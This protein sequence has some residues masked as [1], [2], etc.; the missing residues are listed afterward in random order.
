MNHIMLDLE[1]M[2]TAPDAAIVQVGAVRFDL[3]TGI[4]CSPATHA[5]FTP[6]EQSPTPAL[7][8]WF[9]RTVALQSSLLAGG[10][11]DPDTVAWWRKGHA[12]AKISIESNAERLGVV[13][14]AFS[15]WYP[16]GAI[17]WSHGAAFDVP[18]LDCAYL[19]LGNLFPITAP[20]S[21]R[22]VRDTRTLFWLAELAGWQKPKRE[23]AHTALAD[24]VA[25]AEDVCA[26]YTWLKSKPDDNDGSLGLLT[27]DAYH[28][29]E[30]AKIAGNKPAQ[31]IAH[32][33]HERIC[34]ARSELRGAS[35]DLSRVPPRPR[36]DTP[37]E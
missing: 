7:G 19:S 13:L 10:R 12:E 30:S 26:A 11:I 8:H 17:L 15:T 36:W 6:P 35:F 27:A 24:A 4:V 34:Q 18:V 5:K 32:Y 25:Q 16:P 29:W 28:V 21:Y 1:T 2:S 31:E 22:D 14:S 23:T 9:E 3:E 37:E 33:F 20:W